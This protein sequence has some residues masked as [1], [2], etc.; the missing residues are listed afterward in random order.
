MGKEALYWCCLGVGGGVVV[1]VVAMVILWLASL[2]SGGI[3]L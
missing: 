2:I 1:L 3:S